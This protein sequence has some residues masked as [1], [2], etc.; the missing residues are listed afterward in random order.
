[1][2][3]SSPFFFA[4]ERTGRQA[5]VTAGGHDVLH[6]MLMLGTGH[7]EEEGA[8]EHALMLL[9]LIIRQADVAH[10]FTQ[11]VPP[12]FFVAGAFSCNRIG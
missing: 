1:M 7:G 2:E 11:Q 12:S 10:M 6:D 9:Q 4:G 3:R 8:I 5:I